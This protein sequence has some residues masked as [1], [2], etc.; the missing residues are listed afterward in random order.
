M[1]Y[2][3]IHQ[4]LAIYGEVMKETGGMKGIRDTGLLESAVARPQS[5]FGEEEFYPDIFSKTAALGHSIIRNHPFVDGNKRT[6]YMAMRL[7]LN[8]NGY[9]L[10]ASLKEKYEFV[11]G[12][13]QGMEEKVIAGWLKR[14][15][16]KSWIRYQKS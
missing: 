8:I 16:K 10:K 12:I 15:T 11:M 2:L 4:V 14:H 7:F 3:N 13:A 9:D 1:N 5:G 6:G